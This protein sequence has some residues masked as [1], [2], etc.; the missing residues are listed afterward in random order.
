[1]DK[2]HEMSRGIYSIKLEKDNLLITLHNKYNKPLTNDIFDFIIN[3]NAT[4]IK[5]G[6]HFNQPI[7]N[8]PYTIKSLIFGY[9]F[10]QLLDYLPNSIESI[11]F[12]I[13]FNQ[14]VNNLPN[15]LKSIKFGGK[16]NQSIDNLPNSVEILTLGDGFNQPINKLPTN[17]KSLLIYNDKYNL[18]EL[19]KVK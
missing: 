16:F 2:N 8:L 6:S 9:N 10:N 17:I 18:V 11:E 14:P 13:G 12:G 4:D 19:Y 1:M 7:D 5:F 15:S 3:N